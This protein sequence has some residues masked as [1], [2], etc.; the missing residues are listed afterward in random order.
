[1]DE[2][3]TTEFNAEPNTEKAPRYS[4]AIVSRAPLMAKWLMTMFW[5]NIAHIIIN[6]IKI[7][8]SVVYTTIQNILIAICSLVICLSLFKMRG[9]DERYGRAA[10]FQLLPLVTN[11]IPA[12]V[13]D[14]YNTLAWISV[15]VSL[16]AAVL[17]LLATYNEFHAHSC[18]VGGL[19]SELGDR[20]QKL[21]VWQVIGIAGTFVSLLLT[22]L[23]AGLGAVLVLIVAIYVLVIQIIY[24]VTLY[25][26][27]KAY[28]AVAEGEGTA[29]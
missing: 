24:L 29:V 27:A 5:A 7:E 9:E 11:L 28:R 23:A 1:M 22:V 13:M 14:S 8:S 26:S 4:E 15:L 6:F 2:M 12:L 20:W 25:R 10:L 16:I 18:I 17:T 19:D 21:W 3:N